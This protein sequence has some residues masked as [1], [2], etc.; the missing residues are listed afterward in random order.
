M[1]DPVRGSMRIHAV[2]LATGVPE[3]TLRAW[4]RRYGLPVPARTASGYRLYDARCVA[5]VRE[6]RRLCD[7]GMAA[8]EA[9]RRVSSAGAI[10]RVGQPGEV[11][12]EDPYAN[13]LE[14]ILVAVRAFDEAALERQ[15]QGLMFLGPPVPILD[16]VVTPALRAV[17]DEWHAGELSI[18]QEH[19]ASER[20][21][22]VARDLLRTSSPGGGGPRVLFASFADESHEIGLLCAAV[23]MST[24]GV[25]TIFLG[26]RTPPV[27]LGAAVTAL[28][29]K[30]VALSA[31]VPPNPDTL[32]PLLREY[33]V[34]CGEVPWVVGGLASA[35]L[36][37]PIRAA[38]GHL[39]PVDPVALRSLVRA[40]LG[41]PPRPGR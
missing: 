5:Q 8:A 21:G 36:E 20:L 9:A 13:A 33:A 2:S 7:A 32:R 17:G 12:V 38:G 15:M 1:T 6:M 4:E 10:G 23:R 40:L 39:A 34:A 41:A 30:L 18:A 29:P 19:L 27:A 3:P 25:R 26:A 22:L 28:A 24:W 11:L 37:A 14:A 35:A 31:T 16:R